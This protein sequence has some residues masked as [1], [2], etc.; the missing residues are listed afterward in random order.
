[1][2]NGTIR[3]SPEIG[4]LADAL[5]KAQ[6]EFPTIEKTKTADAG[7]FTYKYAD[8]ADVLAAVRPALSKHGLAFTQPTV[9]EEG[10]IYIRTRLL[11]K[12]GQ[13]QESDYPVA[14]FAGAAHQKI[15]AALTY[16]RRY[17]GCAVLGVAAEEDFDA[18]EDAAKT[19]A[20]KRSA[21]REPPAVVQAGEDKPLPPVVG[22][23]H[24][25]PETIATEEPHEI[26]P[27]QKEDGSWDW[28]EWGSW[29][30]AAY[31]N[32]GDAET[33]EKWT[34][35]NSALLERCLA[36]APKIHERLVGRAEERLDYLTNPPSD[37]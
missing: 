7:T 33:I 37:A 11:H 27:R 4:D 28:I 1:M 35:A 13:W 6:G 31:Q 12:S 20:P 23:R 34:Q 5:A 14:S 24:D 2:D 29:L 19:H 15:G 36:E 16:A 22:E 26:G 30:A 21:K 10:T 25:K 3:T 9:V 18:G 17:A 8:I 32:A